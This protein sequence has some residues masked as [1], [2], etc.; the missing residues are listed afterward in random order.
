ML[1]N[2][3]YFFQAANEFYLVNFKYICHFSL[4]KSL[5]TSIVIRKLVIKRFDTS[6]IC[7]YL[8]DHK[9]ISGKYRLL[10]K[11]DKQ[12]R[13]Y[14]RHLPRSRS[15]RNPECNLL[16][17]RVGRFRHRHGP[18]TPAI[19]L[20]SPNDLRKSRQGHALGSRDKSIF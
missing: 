20:Y 19:N 16:F 3:K 12:W 6:L 1:K 11:G 7:L 18:S 5:F 4:K 9:K 8:N 14:Q 15:V 17:F 10:Q 2:L 13:F